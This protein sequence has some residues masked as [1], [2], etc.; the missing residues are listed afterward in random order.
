MRDEGDYIEAS[1]DEALR[2]GREANIAV[3]ISH[4][5]LTGKKNW[6]KFEKIIEKIDKARNEGIDVAMDEYP[7]IGGQALLASI[8]PDWVHEGGEQMLINRLKDNEMRNKIKEFITKNECT[9]DYGSD[10]GWD[11]IFI[12]SAPKTPQ[13]ACKTVKEIADQLNIDDGYDVIFDLVAANGVSIHMIIFSALEENMIKGYK[14]PYTSVGSDAVPDT[15]V[16][17]VHPRATG[18]FPRFIGKYLRDQKLMSLEEGIRR[19]TSLPASRY[20]LNRKGLI[21]EGFDADITIFDYKTIVDKST[22]IDSKQP[23]E[24]II[25]VIVNGIPAILDGKYTG[26]RP[27]KILKHV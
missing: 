3:Q 9:Y 14:Y 18:T 15:G 4:F 22:Y 19:M 24:G 10:I 26:E 2:I 13:L 12:T 23:P 21:K 8:L 16:P 5:K 1:I 27:G 25:T 6:G 7:Y 20:G 11:N 17:A